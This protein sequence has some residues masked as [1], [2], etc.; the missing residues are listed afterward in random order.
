[1][2]R[3]VIVMVVVAMDA[4]PSR[5][6]RSLIAFVRV[7]GLTFLDGRNENVTTT[8]TLPSGNSIAVMIVVCVMTFD[9]TS[10]CMSVVGELRMHQPPIRYIGVPDAPVDNRIAPIGGLMAIEGVA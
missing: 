1:M 5:D 4:P 9:A 2:P 8:D 7:A 3:R 10:C 6:S